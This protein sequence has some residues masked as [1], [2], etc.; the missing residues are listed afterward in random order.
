MDACRK[1]FLSFLFLV[2]LLTGCEKSPDA[3]PVPRYVA[4]VDVRGTLQ[5]KYTAPE[6]MSSVLNYLR[7]L[8]GGGSPDTD[9]ERITG[10]VYEITLSL[11]DG[12]RRVYRQRANRYLSRDSHPW[13]RIDP[14]LASRLSPLLEAL[15]SD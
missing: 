13:E 10:D 4:Q 6:K 11:S 3:S 7:L 5:R 9:P 14:E 2:F 8:E 12:T 1:I 15:E